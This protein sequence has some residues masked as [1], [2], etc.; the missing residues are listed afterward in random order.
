M[1]ELPS[2]ARQVLLGRWFAIFV[3]FLVMTF[4]GGF[5]LFGYFSNDIRA[6]LNC[7][8]SSLNQIGFYKD[9]G[10]NVGIVTGLLSD[11]APSWVLLVIYATFNFI[12][13]FKVWQGVTG[14]VPNP[15]LGYFSLYMAIAGNSQSIVNTGKIYFY[16]KFSL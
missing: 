12:G 11:V 2:F 7:D 3:S 13:Y 4:A 16:Y 1:G 9:L 14:Q 15:T 10:S 6:K 8:Q 5:Y